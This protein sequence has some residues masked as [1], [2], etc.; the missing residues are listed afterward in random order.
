[1]NV[2]LTAWN[3]GVRETLGSKQHTIQLHYKTP[4]FLP[5]QILQQ[6]PPADCSQK[7]YP[8]ISPYSVNL[9]HWAPI[10]SHAPP[11]VQSFLSP[12]CITDV[13][14]FE[15]HPLSRLGVSTIYTLSTVNVSPGIQPWVLALPFYLFKKQSSVHFCTHQVN[16]PASFKIL[17]SL[18]PNFIIAK[19]GT[20]LLHI[21]TNLHFL[22][23]KCFPKAMD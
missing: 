11:V 15:S 17:L 1:M 7:W 6:P 13:L 4:D 12:L 21:W 2:V 18:P 10:T 14:L 5:H 22:K 8:W 3:P 16:W 19:L 9:P 23:K 20:Y